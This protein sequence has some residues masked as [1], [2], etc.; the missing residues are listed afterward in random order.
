MAHP[1]PARPSKRRRCTIQ[2]VAEDFATV[3]RAEIHRGGI[4]NAGLKDEAARDAKGAGSILSEY[5]AML[6]AVV[7]ALAAEPF[8]MVEDGRLDGRFR[9]SES[10]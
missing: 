4:A 3:K 10:D 6:G 2:R 9:A 7:S 5:G 8:A 1:E